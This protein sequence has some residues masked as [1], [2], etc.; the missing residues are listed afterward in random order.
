MTADG[1][2]RPEVPAQPQEDT[3]RLLNGT[4]RGFVCVPSMATKLNASGLTQPGSAPR[5]TAS[6]LASLR[7]RRQRH[8]RPFRPTQITVKPSPPHGRCP[9]RGR[10]AAGA[11]RRTYHPERPRG[12]V[13]LQRHL[14]PVVLGAVLVQL[15][16][17]VLH[18]LPRRRG[19][20]LLR[21]LPGSVILLLLLVLI[22]PLLG[23]LLVCGTPRR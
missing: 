17:A 8:G 10:P 6:R 2:S 14:Q 15:G 7:T 12:V 21:V 19:H 22:V 20:G 9:A 23:L 11:P 13:G 3:S 16:A 5:V 18:L 4:R 1:T